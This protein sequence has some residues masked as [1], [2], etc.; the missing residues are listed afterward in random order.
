MAIDPSVNT[1][2]RKTDFPGDARQSATAFIIGN[3]G[4]IGFGYNEMSNS[5][6]GDFWSYDASSDSWAR[7][8]DFPGT[9][10]Y[11]LVGFSIG[12]SGYIGTGNNGGLQDF[13][14]FNP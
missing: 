9:P 4:F 10:R 3:K 13:W 12:N 8:A 6:L 11:D 2:S 5:A 1:W 7:E 14:Q